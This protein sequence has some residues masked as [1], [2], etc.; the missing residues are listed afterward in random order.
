[1][2]EY[3]LSELEKFTKLKLDA[4]RYPKDRHTFRS[5]KCPNCG[6][7]PVALTIEHHTGSTS[8]NF[9]GIIRVTCSNCDDEFQFLSFT[10]E[11]RKPE[12]VE[13]PKCICG[14]YHFLTAESERY[15]GGEGIPGFFDEGVV[16]GQCAH[17]GRH[18]V[19]VFTD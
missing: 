18:Q 2:N 9:R 15:E 13:M 3:S 16:A 4:H 1:M 17:C 8:D 14:S 11:H 6:I 10:G 12:F 19:F 7:M 5:A